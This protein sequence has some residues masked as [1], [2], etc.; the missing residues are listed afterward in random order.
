[1]DIEEIFSETDF[2][3][4]LVNLPGSSDLNVNMHVEENPELPKLT[5]S[6]DQ[7]KPK[8]SIYYRTIYNE[9]CFL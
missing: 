3:S 9:K 4:L 8:V 5:N 2:D 7:S 1:M 6:S